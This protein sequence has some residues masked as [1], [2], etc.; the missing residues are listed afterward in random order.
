[1]YDPS[2]DSRDVDI[3]L[4]VVSDC[5][6]SIVVVFQPDLG[7]STHRDFRFHRPVWLTLRLPTLSRGR[8][9]HVLRRRLQVVVVF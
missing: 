1:M 4:K 6:K 5:A 7:K 2:E 9:L 3:T 8:L